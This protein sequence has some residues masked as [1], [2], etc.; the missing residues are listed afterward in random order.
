[1]VE[2]E[3]ICYK[4]NDAA[5]NEI[6]LAKLP[7]EEAKTVKIHPVC[8]TC[9]ECQC[10]LAGTPYVCSD[11]NFYCEADY[12]KLFNPVCHHCEEN[13]RGECV[14]ALGY[15]WCENH[16]VCS[17][18][19]TGFPNN[20][21][22]KI[23]NQPYCKPCYT[24]RTKI[25]CDTCGENIENEILQALDRNYHRNCFTCKAGGHFMDENTKI[26]QYEGD[27]YCYD[28]LIAKL[29]FSCVECQEPIFGEYIKV[30]DKQIHK[31][32]W[33]CKVC[34]TAL[35]LNANEVQLH[36]SDFYCKNCPIPPG[37]V[38]EHT[39]EHRRS[40]IGE[41]LPH[42][43]S[44][45]FTFEQMHNSNKRPNLPEGIDVKHREAYLDGT[46]FE[47]L[48][49]MTKTKFYGLAKWRQKQKKMEVGL[50]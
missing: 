50:F 7:G 16:F 38:A 48:F 41:L 1:M 37:A 46:T 10:T 23:D 20:E 3:V 11:N 5:T 13:V 6:V 40:I 34:R 33:K 49:G 25:A 32:C 15:T 43:I 29:Q 22:H 24:E 8:F 18:C 45:Y 44:E 30:F 35:P 12:V 21:F 26:V 2:G 27:L 39:R 4:C 42:G 14:K 36:D 31:A 47:K 19:G 28:H 17:D 9:E